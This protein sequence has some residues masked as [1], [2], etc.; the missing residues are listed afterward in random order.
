MTPIK[1]GFDYSLGVNRRSEDTMFNFNGVVKTDVG[2]LDFYHV[3]GREDRESQLNYRGAVVW[4][5]NKISFTKMVDNAFTL[6]KVGDYQ[7]I[8]ILRSLTYVDK[9]NKRGM[10]LF[11]MLFLMLNTTLHLIKINYLSK[12]KYSIQ[13]NN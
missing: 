8:D 6:V 13:V 5:G 3:Q 7:D 12:I 1:S 2:D 10:P 9:T 11:M 4:L